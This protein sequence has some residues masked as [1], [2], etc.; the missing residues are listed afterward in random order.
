MP[1]MW[2]KTLYKKAFGIYKPRGLFS[3]SAI[4]CFQLGNRVDAATDITRIIYSRTSY[5]LTGFFFSFC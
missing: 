4:P 2:V 5:E 3:E 1:V